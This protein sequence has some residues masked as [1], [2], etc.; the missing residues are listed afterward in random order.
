MPDHSPRSAL[1]WSARYG[2]EHFPHEAGREEAWDVVVEAFGIEKEFLR[3]LLDEAA[4]GK[5]QLP[6]FQR[7]WVWPMENIR[8][9]LAS[10]S[11]GYPV[12]TLM[13]MKTG[14]DVKFKQ[15][16]IQGAA[17]T[18]P[19][20]R[21]ILDGQQRITSL[22]QALKL[23]APIETQDVRKRRLSGWFYVDIQAALDPHAD[24]EEAFLFVPAD[25]KERN[26]RGEV[27]RDLSEAEF[28]YAADLFPLK[29]AFSYDDWMDGYDEYWEYSQEKRQM[30]NTFRQEVLKRFDTYQVP[31]IELAASTPREAVCQ[32]FEKVNTG[33]VTLTV[34]ELLTATYAADEFDLRQD[35]ES[36]RAAWT[37]PA[38]KVLHEVANT[39]FLQAV[40]LLSTHAA[41]TDY[42]SKGG[43]D[44]RAP[45]V[46]C[47]R[48]DILRMPLDSYRQW[49]Q[50]AVAGFKAAAKLLHQQHIFDT[51][52]LPYGSQ[53]IPLAAIFALLGTDATSANAQQKLSRWLWCGIFG[54]LY[55]GTTETRFARDVPDVV[56]WVREGGLDPRTVQEAQFAPG[57]LETLRTRQS[58]A[59]KGIYAMLMKRD[60]LDWRSGE[61]MSVTT[62]FD[63]YVDI[64]HIFPK[65]WC[66]RQGVKPAIY[67]SIVNKT[68]L[69]ARTN[70][71]IGGYAPSEYLHRV[72]NS[73]GVGRDQVG[74]NVA[75]HFVDVEQLAAD[76]FTA[77]MDTRR[78]ALLHLIADA[79]GKPIALEQK[80]E[81]TTE[82]EYLEEAEDGE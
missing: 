2:R 34:F 50:A 56:G 46:G 27:E 31:V 62:Y 21:L 32:V 7:D 48:I 36:R 19:A 4:S 77:F 5:S 61:P 67:N 10:I 64:H 44:D 33:G 53:L 51:K 15:R 47:R 35:W 71:V 20:E 39:D 69:T 8:S 65:A 76:D 41:R 29:S 25:R 49:A 74:S 18:K 55:G 42:L 73:A 17:P 11:L 80:V 22:F 30:R 81:G 24:R 70:R 9:L 43:E 63:E 79:M 28:E 26:F 14:G 66:D 72:A 37:D 23:G 13:M 45:R 1:R 78:S 54:E 3:G 16:P 52:F 40:A 38:Y 75:T 58:A 59:Y 57:R 12:G 6:E 60:A 82:A 68:P